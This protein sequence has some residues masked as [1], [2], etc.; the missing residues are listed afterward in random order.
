MR[1]RIK[2][3]AVVI[4][5]LMVTISLAACGSAGSFNE[6]VEN[7]KEKA[8][9][10]KDQAEQKYNEIAGNLVDMDTES[11]DIQAGYFTDGIYTI[12]LKNNSE[13]KVLSK[14]VFAFEGYDADGNPLEPV[15]FPPNGKAGPLFP[16]ESAVMLDWGEDSWPEQLSE[17]RYSVTSANWG[18]AGKHVAISDTAENYYGNYTVTISNTGSGDVDLQEDYKDFKFDTFAVFRDSEGTVT[19]V[20]FAHYDEFETT[21]ENGEIVGDFPT[22]EA[23]SD[24]TTGVT[25]YDVY[26]G[27]AEIVMTWM[28]R[29]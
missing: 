8:E 23:G 12:V 11:L 18:G 29:M 15:G 10:L 17:M 28:P 9:E 5:M 27:T 6:T 24:I 2:S 13:D 26:P 22:I 7:A 14:A 3:V 25:V 1:N 16:G 19:G 20:S 4:C 21:D